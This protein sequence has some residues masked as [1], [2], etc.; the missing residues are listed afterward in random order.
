MQ[1]QKKYKKLTV[2]VE[3]PFSEGIVKFLQKN[4]RQYSLKEIQS[5]VREGAIRVNRSQNL[6]R[7]ELKPGDVVE[8]FMSAASLDLPLPED[9]SLDI[10]YE[11]ENLIVLNKPAG[12]AV[13]PAPGTPNH[14][15]VN[16]LLHHAPTLSS[17]NGSQSPGIV[18]RLDKDTSGLMLVAKNNKTHLAL[19]DMIRQR[20]V[21]RIYLALVWGKVRIS[22]GMISAPIGVSHQRG[23][24]YAVS[25]EGGKPSKTQYETLSANNYFSLMRF[26]LLTGRT[27]QIRLHAAHI[28]HPIVG[29]DDYCTFTPESGLLDLKYDDAEL[30]LKVLTRIKKLKRQMLHA[31]ELSFTN[32]INGKKMYFSS[33]PPKDFI[34]LLEYL[35]KFLLGI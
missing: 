1:K 27:H 35:R 3:A 31:A 23:L 21:K 14:T 2:A 15:L 32:P 8:I 24:R 19:S 17:I 13:H 4:L 28:N 18:H 5:W 30:Y 7:K 29:D 20:Q 10:L 16:A 33:E 9:I 11:D 25:H 26:S 6:R 12:L 34:E 22:K